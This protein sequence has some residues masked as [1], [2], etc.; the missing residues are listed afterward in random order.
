[1][2]NLPSKKTSDPSYQHLTCL[3]ALLLQS[4]RDPAPPWPG[5]FPWLTAAHTGVS[6]HLESRSLRLV[7]LG[8]GEVRKGSGMRTDQPP[9]RVEQRLLPSQGAAGCLGRGVSPGMRNALTRPENRGMGEPE[10]SGK[11][12]DHRRGTGLGRP[13][14]AGLEGRAAEEGKEVGAAEGGEGAGE[15]SRAGPGALVWDPQS[16]CRHCLCRGPCLSRNPGS[17]NG[18]GIYP[19]SS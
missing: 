5:A 12:E 6:L 8:G 9:S 17:L 4:H 11:K 19:G 10:A 2:Y 7:P 1:M 15:R 14:K 3:G 16:P 18:P 13:R